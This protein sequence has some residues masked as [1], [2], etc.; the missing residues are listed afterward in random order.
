ME[1][2]KKLPMQSQILRKIINFNFKFIFMKNINICW[3]S[4]ILEDSACKFLEAYLD[5]IKIYVK[6]NKLDEDLLNDIESR[7]SER[8]FEI[9]EKNQEIV[10]KDVI[11][12]VNEI[13][14]PED[15]FKDFFWKKEDSTNFKWRTLFRDSK[16]W[17]LFW[18]CQWL[19]EYFDKSPIIFRI[20]FLLLVFAWFWI[21][22]YLVLV[23]LIPDKNQDLNLR[24]D[25]VSKLRDLF[26]ICVR[27][28]WFFILFFA[29]AFILVWWI[30]VLVWWAFINSNIIIDN[31][32]I[33]YYVSQTLIIEIFVFWA[34]LVAFWVM[35]FLGSIWKDTFWSK[36]FVITIVLIAL[37]WSLWTSS[38]LNIINKYSLWLD[39]H[40]SFV[41]ENTFSGTTLSLEI[42]NFW[43]NQTSHLMYFDVWIPTSIRIEK[44]ED[45]KIHVNVISSIRWENEKAAQEILWKT[46]PILAS[47]KNNTILISKENSLDFKEV[48]PFSLFHRE[49][50]LQI[51]EN[52]KIDTKSLKTNNYYLQ[53]V[54]VSNRMHELGLTWR[55]VCEGQIL[56][57]NQD[58]WG[59]YCNNDQVIKERINEMK[60]EYLEENWYEIFKSLLWKEKARKFVD[61]GYSWIKVYDDYATLEAN[62]IQDDEKIK[63]K[64]QLREDNWKIVVE[65][66]EIV[67]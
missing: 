17:I 45:S 32:A 52:I 43:F 11:N 39:K 9:K 12:I 46:Y 48:V 2:G 36:W 54:Y 23:F 21:P 61:F 47:L 59:F 29:W 27:I 66:K 22:L 35:L 57:F 28:V 5:R 58:K 42:E 37:F 49:I 4:F 60:R 40:E 62:N 25:F 19:W 13:W 55:H 38:V 56:S 16:N 63:I 7:I 14:E 18:V 1:F 31:Q 26:K 33:F 34:L 64:V 24:G 51:P 20:L 3:N 15:I 6:K 50:L 30:W 10:E 41:F 67:K 8:F 53:N 44:S 65:S